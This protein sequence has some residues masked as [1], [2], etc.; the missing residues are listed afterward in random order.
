V[1]TA[2]F[3]LLVGAFDAS[4]SWV[5]RSPAP[6]SLPLFAQ[7]AAVWVAM[8]GLRWI[9]WLT[10]GIFVLAPVIMLLC[11]AL[12]RRSVGRWHIILWVCVS[13]SA[14]ALTR[15]AP[16]PAPDHPEA[17]GF[18]LLWVG[19]A[20]GAVAV[21]SAFRLQ[22][23]RRGVGRSS[24]P[25]WFLLVTAVAVHWLWSPLAALVA[26]GPVLFG[27]RDDQLPPRVVRAPGD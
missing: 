24:F 5:E 2:P 18:V 19:V 11:V 12:M 22:Q 6:S 8:A 14:W 21:A 25:A 9:P 15:I 10:A 16:R 26:T 3:V 1:F 23:L 13:M 20:S 4:L 17:L 27:L 7:Q